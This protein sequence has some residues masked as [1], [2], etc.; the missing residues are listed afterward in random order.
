MKKFYWKLQNY[1]I[2]LN[3][4]WAWGNKRSYLGII[5]NRGF[6]SFYPTIN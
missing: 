1:N 5:Y 4:K 3:R 6:I 2:E